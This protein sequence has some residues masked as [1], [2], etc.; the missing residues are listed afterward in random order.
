MYDNISLIQ[1]I[2]YKI[3]IGLILKKKVKFLIFDCKYSGNE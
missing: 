1:K 3:N 2:F